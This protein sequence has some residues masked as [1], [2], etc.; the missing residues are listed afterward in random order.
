[1]SSAAEGDLPGLPRQ[2]LVDHLAVTVPELAGL[3]LTTSLISGGRSNLTYLVQCGAE[4]WVLRRPPLGD[5]V[6]TAHDVTREWRLLAALHPSTVPMPRPVHLCEDP[7]VIGAPFYV[8]AY[9]DGSVLRDRVQLDEVADP[10]RLGRAMIATLADLHRVDPESV[11]LGDL[12]RP[13]G[14]LQRQLVRWV[15]QVEAND[16]PQAADLAALAGRLEATRPTS[17]RTSIVH[18]DFRLDNVVVG[19]A[20]GADPSVVAVLDWEMATR[21]DPL[22]DLAST[23][24]WW[25]GMT[26]ID[27]PVATM[28]GDV[29]G[30]PSGDSLAEHYATLTG[31]DLGDLPWYL[32]FA[33]FKVA[34]IFDG[35]RRRTDDGLSVG[36]GFELL[37]PLVPEL[38][39]RGSRAL[40]TAPST[41][42]STG[43]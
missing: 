11:G 5:V 26:G 12:G 21:G 30:W 20:V 4:R 32:A 28:P 42:P 15:R 6:A 3:D 17:R 36:D 31:D 8:M 23:V 39:A 35:L 10:G 40:T 41:V 29:A 27:L 25:D 13:D 34:G 43:A 1:M 9:A 14:Y 16:S 19:G 24:A 37:G 33:Y 7:S 2:A 22:A 38:I 18:G